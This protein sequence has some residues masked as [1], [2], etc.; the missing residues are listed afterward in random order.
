[1]AAEVDTDVARK[2]YWSVEGDVMVGLYLDAT[3]ITTACLERK[4]DDYV[5]V[6]LVSIEVNDAYKEYMRTILE[7]EPDTS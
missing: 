4:D 3:Q 6:P 2:E 5:A 1:M 7:H